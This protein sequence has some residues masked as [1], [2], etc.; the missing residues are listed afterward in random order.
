MYLSSCLP[1]YQCVYSREIENYPTIPENSQ[2]FGNVPFKRLRIGY[3]MK[4]HCSNVT[5]MLCLD[6]QNTTLWQRQKY[7]KYVIL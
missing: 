2:R 6:G 1:Q 7:C 3:V 4:E 5:T